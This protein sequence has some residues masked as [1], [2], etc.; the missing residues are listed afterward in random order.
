MATVLRFPP[1]QP[2]PL[3]PDL[4]E[5]AAAITLIVRGA[6]RQVRLVN[7]QRPLAVA[8]DAAAQAGQSG[9]EFYVERST[10]RAELVVGPKR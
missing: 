3:E 10:G 8:G 1:C 7:L 5:I 2:A 6:A 4:A 9:V